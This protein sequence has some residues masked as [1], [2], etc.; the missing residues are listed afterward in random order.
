[1]ENWALSIAMTAAIALIIGAVFLW[2]RS[3]RG[4]AILMVLAALVLIGNVV[5]WTV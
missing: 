2:R 3:E 5:I 4:K 1:V